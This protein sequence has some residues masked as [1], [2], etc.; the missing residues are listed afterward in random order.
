MSLVVDKK[1]IGYYVTLKWCDCG[2]GV[3]SY[4]LDYNYGSGGGGGGCSFAKPDDEKLNLRGR[5]SER[6]A[7][8]A[9]CEYALRSLEHCVWKPDSKVERLKRMVEDYMKSLSRPKVV[10]LSLFD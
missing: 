10:Q 6:E 4:G 5:T 3:W 8:I 1:K 7:K 2:N 9:A